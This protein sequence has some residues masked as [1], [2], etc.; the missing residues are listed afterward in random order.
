MTGTSTITSTVNPTGVALANSTSLNV[1]LTGMA[2]SQAL[3]A[4]S[5]NVTIAVPSS[6]ANTYISFSGTASAANF[7]I[8]AGFAF[9]FTGL[10][11]V[12]TVYFFGAAATG[13]ISIFAH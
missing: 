11:A 10:P 8:P 9:T 12:S 1:G 3:V 5:S 6:A 7:M 13:A 2:Q 4:A